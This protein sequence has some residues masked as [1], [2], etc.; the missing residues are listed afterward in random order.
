MYLYAINRKGFIGMT[1]LKI[2]LGA[3]TKVGTC[4]QKA[5][6]EKCKP[7]YS[8]KNNEKKKEK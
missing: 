2:K 6:K 1:C 5:R 4:G 8:R 7:K 3:K